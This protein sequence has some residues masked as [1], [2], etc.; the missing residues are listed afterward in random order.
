M[1][2][3]SKEDI[4]RAFLGALGWALLAFLVLTLTAGALLSSAFLSRVDAIGRTAEAIIR[5]EI[6]P[7]AVPARHE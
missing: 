4:R 5:M 1:I 7:R 6:L 2:C 3:E